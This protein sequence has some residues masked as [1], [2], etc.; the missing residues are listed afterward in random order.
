MILKSISGISP[1]WAAGMPA[2]IGDIMAFHSSVALPKYVG[3]TWLKN[4]SGDFVSKD[5]RISKISNI[6]LRYYLEEV[7]NSVRRHIPEYT[8]YYA[9]KYAEVTK[10]QHK[11]SLALT[12]RNFFDSILV[13]WSKNN[14]TPANIGTP[15]LLNAN[16][17]T[18]LTFPLT[19][20]HFPLRHIT[21]FPS[22]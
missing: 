15:M 12:S 9:R 17:L 6:Y 13:C 7:I 11:K 8:Q 4:D 20:N 19:S 14:C 22:S 10:H 5:N 1:V 21:R 3:L 18:T 2:E 16:F